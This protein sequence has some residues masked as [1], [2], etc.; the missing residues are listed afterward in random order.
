M[1]YK[2]SRSGNKN[3]NAAMP[4]SKMKNILQKKKKL[5]KPKKSSRNQTRECKKLIN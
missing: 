5:E 2:H 1:T 4:N 3:A